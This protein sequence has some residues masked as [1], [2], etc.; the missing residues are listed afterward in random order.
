MTNKYDSETM[1]ALQ[2][3]KSKFNAL[4][5]TGMGKF[6]Y[7]MTTV[8]VNRLFKLPFAESSLSSLPRAWEYKSSDVRYFCRYFGDSPLKNV[9][10]GAGMQPDDLIQGVRSWSDCLK[11]TAY[12]VFMFSEDKLYRISVRFLP[13][14][15]PCPELTKS[16]DV[17]AKDYD[18]PVSGAGDERRLRY[19]TDEVSLD[20]ASSPEGSVRFD[21][22]QR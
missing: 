11:R 1:G 2:R 3:A 4:F 6:Q 20:A 10:C 8:Q 13:D 18:I 9:G 17:F 12:A 7:G 16:V 19:E 15:P 21:F 14:I 22:V 5:G